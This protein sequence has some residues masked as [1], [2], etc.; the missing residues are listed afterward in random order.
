[1]TYLNIINKGTN[2]LLVA[3]DKTNSE[4]YSI[5]CVTFLL[6][7]VYHLCSISAKKIYLE[8]HHEQL[9]TQAHNHEETIRQTQTVIYATTGLDFPQN[10]TVTKENKQKRWGRGACAEGH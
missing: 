10:A 4:E 6:K 3:P 5:T 7:N 2:G 9:S 1:M 8:P